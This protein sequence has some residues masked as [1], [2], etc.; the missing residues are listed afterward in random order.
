MEHHSPIMDDSSYQR[1][2]ESSQS[3]RG[4]IT[5]ER[6]HFLSEILGSIL[7]SRDSTD[8]LS[9]LERVADVQRSGSVEKI[10]ADAPRNNRLRK[11]QRGPTVM[12]LVPYERNSLPAFSKLHNPTA[13]FFFANHRFC[14]S[15]DWNRL[16]VAAV[17]WDAAVVLCMYLELGRV[18]LC[19]KTAIELGA[20]TGLVG[21]VAA[22]FGAH[23]TI[24]DRASALDFLHANVR[25]NIP[26][27][28]REAVVVSELTWGENL[29]R[30]MAGGYDLVLGA[31]IVY[32]EDTFPALLRTLEHLSSDKTVVLLA[33]RIRYERDQKF[34]HI[35][36]QRFTLQEVHYE[37]ERD[38]HIYRAMITKQEL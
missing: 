4:D 22:L 38:I 14:I 1:C 29:E 27:E 6:S 37:A 17:V 20:G 34:L 26:P 10:R 7:S 8:N 19:G 25:N 24:T 15:Q 13:E 23:V 11:Q 16:G 35:L 12:A 31:D 5:A 2:L 28:K 21:M 33:C 36:Q 3:R 30:Y 18:E 9:G 32:L